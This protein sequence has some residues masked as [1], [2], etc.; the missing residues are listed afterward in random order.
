[1]K[2]TATSKVVRDLPQH[3][4]IE[5]ETITIRMKC[6]QKTVGTYSFPL[7]DWLDTEKGPS[8][9]P[10]W[11]RIELIRSHTLHLDEQS[12]GPC[13][14]ERIRDAQVS[15]IKKALEA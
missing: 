8:A 11:N 1:M 5:G 2:K 6:G 9:N 3:A 10:N 15:A 14:A 12:G 4:T 13:Q 7:Q